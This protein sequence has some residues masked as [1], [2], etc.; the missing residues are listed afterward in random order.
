MEC[1]SEIGC[2]MRLT[3]LLQ[4]GWTVGDQATNACLQRQ[5]SLREILAAVLHQQDTDVQCVKDCLLLALAGVV[6]GAILENESHAAAKP[7]AYLVASDQITFVAAE[8]RVRAV[9]SLV[10]AGTAPGLLSQND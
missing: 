10:P 3:A 2:K 1:E 6:V 5:G 9:S 8:S 4:G 7:A